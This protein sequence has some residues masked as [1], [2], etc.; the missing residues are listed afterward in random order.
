MMILAAIVQVEDDVFLS[1]SA[2]SNACCTDCLT[3]LANSE[4]AQYYIILEM[5][6][7]GKFHFNRK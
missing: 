4:I 3:C 6:S 5:D 2:S 1:F 7:T